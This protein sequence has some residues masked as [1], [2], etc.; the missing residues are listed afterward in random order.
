MAMKCEEIEKLLKDH[1]CDAS[2]VIEDLAGDGNHYR[3]IITSESFRGKSRIEQHK[4]VYAALQGKMGST[5][6]ALSLV[7]QAPENN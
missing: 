1:F 7:T 4:M 3:A 5:L 6:H 2:I